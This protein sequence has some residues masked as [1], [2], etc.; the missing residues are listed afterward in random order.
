[1][2]VPTKV[3]FLL[4]GAGW[5]LSVQ[6]EE[7]AVY[8]ATGSSTAKPAAV[9]KIVGHA[10]KGATYR[11]SGWT[12]PRGSEEIN[13]RLRTERAESVKR[14][15][16]TAGV[17][18][19]LIQLEDG[20]SA[21]A[22]TNPKDYWKLRRATVRYEPGRGTPVAR[23]EKPAS[24]PTTATATAAPPAEGASS[25]KPAEA[26]TKPAEG[27]TAVAMASTSTSTGQPGKAG[28][29]KELE[30]IRLI[31]WRALNHALWIVAK[32]KGFFE[33]EGFDVDLVETDEDARVIAKHVEDAKRGSVG[34]AGGVQSTS[35]L[36]R[37]QKRFAAGAVCGFATHEAMARNEPVV[38]IG[39]MIMIPESLLMKKSLAERLDKDIRA[40][41]GAKMGDITYGAGVHDFKYS[42]ILRVQLEKNGLKEGQDFQIGEYKDLNDAYQALAAGKIDIAKGF[43]PSDIEF[44]RSH[45]DFVRVPFAKFFPYLPCCRQVVT[46]A[47]LKDHR[48]R[49]VRLLRA[50]I[51]AHQFIVL[52]PKEAAEVIGQWLKIPPALVR[53][54]I[55][56]AYVTLTPDPM[57][58]GVELYQRANDRFTHTT[59]STAEFIDTSL[60]R[61]A[62]FGLARENEDPE[63]QGY[64][65]T[66][67]SRFRTNN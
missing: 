20:G 4:L 13:R 58:K 42:N 52:H 29:K 32:Q 7:A 23:G 50:S 28:G 63:A 38:D 40:F 47:Q 15:L 24:P 26:A 9:R 56:S 66:V 25:A 43:P 44:V 35:A 61:D 67:I 30:H 55:M 11:V 12:D 10:G 45:P 14:A 51:R 1:M 60:Y 48:D 53:Q 49:Y 37:G 19:D 27:G 57:R 34:T 64:F 33:Q 17:G 41:K 62:L 16:L 22:S 54:S 21:P 18:E 65:A 31:Y 3:I 36:E 2:R 46:R 5:A 8:F 59:T 6:A 39:S